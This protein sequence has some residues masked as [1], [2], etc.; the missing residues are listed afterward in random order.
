MTGWF[1]RR[2]GARSMDARRLIFRIAGLL[3][4]GVWPSMSGHS[5]SA[6]QE[7]RQKPEGRTV[8]ARLA[9]FSNAPFESPKL[10]ENEIATPQ[11]VAW[12]KQMIRDN[13]PP[14]YQDDRK[15]NQQKEVWDGVKIWREGN[16][17]ETKRR[18]KLVNA[19]TW[20]KYSIAIVDPDDNL[21]IEFHRLEP[22]ADG[23]IAF[24]VTVD[25]TLDVFGRLSQWARDVQLISLS[26]N[27]DAACRLTLEGTVALHLNV[28]KLPPDVAIK[29][30]VT[31]AHIDLTYYNVRRISQVGGEFAQVLGKGLRFTLDDRLDDLN[32][33]LADK[34]N[35]QL[36]KQSHRFAFSTQAWLKSKLPIPAVSQPR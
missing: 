8:P 34:I 24:S 5:T 27:A 6:Q 33:K 21:H 9:A 19:G 23:K 17:L 22:Q 2:W 11:M 31:H 14:T 36:D 30:H 20:T 16:H 10:V 35:S 13:L 15:W 26:A 32:G 3:A 12:L 18:T 25:C 29:P 4:F 7:V 28:L 1:A